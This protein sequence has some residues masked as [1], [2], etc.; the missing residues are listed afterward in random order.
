VGQAKIIAGPAWTDTATQRFVLSWFNRRPIAVANNFSTSRSTA[1][2]TFVEVNSEVRSEFLLW[3]GDSVYCGINVL[4]QIS[5]SGATAQGGVGVD[6]T[7]GTPNG[8]E[9]WITAPVG[10]FDGSFGGTVAVSGLAEG[11]HFV[12]VLAKVDTGSTTLFQNGSVT[13]AFLMG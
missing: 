10:G 13:T 2:A 4:A 12:T 5:T 3:S 9:G 7:S 8:G 6:I 11:A 1:S